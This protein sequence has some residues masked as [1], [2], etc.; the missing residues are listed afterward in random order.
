VR[1]AVA[2]LASSG[3]QVRVVAADVADPQAAERLLA[4]LEATLPPLGGVVHTAG[5]LSDAVLARQGWDTFA[6]VLAPK[7]RGAWNLHRLTAGRKLDFFIAFSSVAGLLGSP[8]QANYSA[9][10][11][12][13]DALA[14]T[15]RAQGLPAVSIDWGPWAE[16]GM[17]ADL[18]EVHR[19]R[20]AARG[21]VALP[22]ERGLRALERLATGAPQV[23]V[24]D[25]DWQAL[26]AS[27]AR[28]SPLLA[29]LL[30]A[31]SG[32][33]SPAREAP[34][35]DVLAELS[36]LPERQRL[37]RVEELV[38]AE[39]C[40]VLG[41][42]G[43]SQLEPHRGF[44]DAGMD[45]LMTLELRNRLQRL[46]G[47]PLSASVVFNYPS[48]HQLGGYLATLLAE[49]PAPAAPEPA[50]ASAEPPPTPTDEPEAALT[51]DEIA[52]LVAE[53]YAQTQ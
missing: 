50:R 27:S 35:A 19:R 21:M 4:E 20:L 49:A 38:H 26:R 47:R 7:V 24:L 9:A 39:V 43:P 15:R 25:A 30:Q 23:A 34:V 45:S 28:E 17:A 51:D 29:E 18:D 8:G 16:G 53:K 14:H 6:P 11:A 3:A 44:A 31:P 42:A 52:R 33:P 32:T 13:L 12:F 48:V 36:A 37:Q 22:V 1:E 46:L 5:V 40:R 2:A 10:N 41:L